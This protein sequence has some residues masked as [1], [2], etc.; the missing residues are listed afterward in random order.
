MPQP[1]NMELFINISDAIKK[2]YPEIYKKLA[3][4]DEYQRILNELENYILE[5]ANHRTKEVKDEK[6]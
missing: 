3:C 1:I 4:D 5:P 6:I 2:T